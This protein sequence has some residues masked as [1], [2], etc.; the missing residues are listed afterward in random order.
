MFYK[1]F[2][3]RRRCSPRSRTF[4]QTNAFG[5]GKPF[6]AKNDFPGFGKIS[7][8]VYKQ[9]SLIVVDFLCALH[10]FIVLHSV[11]TQNSLTLVDF[12]LCFPAKKL[13]SKDFP[14]CSTRK[15]LNLDDFLC[16]LHAKILIFD[17]LFCVFTSKSLII[18]LI[19]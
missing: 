7:F 15:I 9:K 5:S 2:G 14:L 18:D 16:V 4:A 12:P 1:P 11:Y 6:F 17:D 19:F 8:V 13:I 3:A 10:V